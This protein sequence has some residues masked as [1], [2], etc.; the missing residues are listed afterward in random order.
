MVFDPIVCV[1][2]VWELTVQ[3]TGALVEQTLGPLSSSLG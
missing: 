2:I 3:C 1:L